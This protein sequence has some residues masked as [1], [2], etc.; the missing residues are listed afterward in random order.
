[1]SLVLGCFV[2]SLPWRTAGVAGCDGAT[3]RCSEGGN[4]G[5]LLVIVNDCFSRVSSDSLIESGDHLGS[6]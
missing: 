2:F 4:L 3:E 1:M 6:R 5:Y